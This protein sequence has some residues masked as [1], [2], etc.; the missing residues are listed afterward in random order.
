MEL[1]SNQVQAYLIFLS[2]LQNTSDLLKKLYNLRCISTNK[3]ET[4]GK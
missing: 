2:V 4:L 1:Q 3:P